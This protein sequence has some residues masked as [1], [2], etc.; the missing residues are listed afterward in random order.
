MRTIICILMYILVITDQQNLNDIFLH[1][2]LSEIKFDINFAES[3]SQTSRS[4]KNLKRGR[5]IDFRKVITIQLIY[6][7]D[8]D[9]IVINKEIEAF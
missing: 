5:E 7:R 4:Y 2:P 1:L 8:N 9:T 6:N 3:L